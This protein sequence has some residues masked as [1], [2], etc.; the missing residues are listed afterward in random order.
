VTVDGAVVAYVFKDRAT[1]S[2]DY[3]GG[4]LAYSTER[5][6]WAWESPDGTMGNY[7]FA[8]RAAAVADVP[9]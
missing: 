1:T 5:A 3:A 9:R 8:S 7:D 6:S 2:R 4:R